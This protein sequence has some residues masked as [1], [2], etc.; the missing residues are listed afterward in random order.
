MIPGRGPTASENKAMRERP[1][2]K[3]LTVERLATLSLVSLPT[4][5]SSLSGFCL[6]PSLVGTH[7]NVCK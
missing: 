2:I 5:E 7:E 6:W 1:M 3:G 4:Y